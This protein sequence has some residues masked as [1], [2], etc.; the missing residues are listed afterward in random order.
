MNVKWDV[1]KGESGIISDMADAIMTGRVGEG[2]DQ[3]VTNGKAD[4]GRSDLRGSFE[5]KSN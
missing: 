4:P 5:V 2:G 1:N 3:G